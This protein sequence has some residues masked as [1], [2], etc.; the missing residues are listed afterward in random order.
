MVWNKLP[1]DI[2][3][4]QTTDHL[5]TTAVGYIAIKNAL[6]VTSSPASAD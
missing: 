5:G 3:L 2:R 1:I 4:F 6:Q